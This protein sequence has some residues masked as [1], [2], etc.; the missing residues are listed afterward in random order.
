MSDSLDKYVPEFDENEARNKLAGLTS[1]QLTD[2]L[3]HEYK[4]KRVIAKMLDAETRKLRRIETIVA[5]SNS[6]IKMPGIPSAE[7]LRRMMGEE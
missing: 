2:M 4:L 1:V 5:E 7:D 6:L 3:I